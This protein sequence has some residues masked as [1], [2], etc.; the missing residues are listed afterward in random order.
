MNQKQRLQQAISILNKRLVSQ[1]DLAQVR[2][3]LNDEITVNE[4]TNDISFFAN[5]LM[6][7]V[8]INIVDVL[9]IES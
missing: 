2:S 9:S 7:D 5:E 6:T 3:I 4:N 1:E 8:S